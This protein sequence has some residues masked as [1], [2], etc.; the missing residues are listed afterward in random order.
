[1]EAYCLKCKTK[2]PL[3]KYEIKTTVNKNKKYVQGACGTCNSKCN[4]FLP[5]NYTINTEI[6]VDG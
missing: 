2:V 4:K 5:N 6:K 3:A 1:M